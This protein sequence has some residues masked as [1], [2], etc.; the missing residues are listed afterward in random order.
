MRGFVTCYLLLA[1]FIV[2]CFLPAMLKGNQFE[3]P[4]KPKSE[5]VKE[6]K[7]EPG[8]PAG[9]LPVDVVTPPVTNWAQVVTA[10]VLGFLGFVKAME[11]L[12][13]GWVAYQASR[14][15][16]KTAGLSAAELEAIITRVSENVIN[17]AKGKP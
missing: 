9:P 16:G 10:V 12:Y 15:A 14:K 2:C 1:A 11:K 4:D 5:P 3:A 13:D 8:R 6:A 7:I 17:A